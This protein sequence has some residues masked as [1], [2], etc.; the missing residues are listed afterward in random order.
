MQGYFERGVLDFVL[1]RNGLG[2]FFVFSVFFFAY[3]YHDVRLVENRNN[4]NS[5]VDLFQKAKDDQ[6][7]KS[8]VIFEDMIYII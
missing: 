5:A 2:D 7:T 6:C 4:L 3:M 8:D 1:N